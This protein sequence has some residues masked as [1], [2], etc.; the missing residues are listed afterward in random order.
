[1]RPRWTPCQ[2]KG[3]TSSSLPGKTGQV[4]VSHHGHIV[5]PR[6]CDN[7]GVNQARDG[8][9][10]FHYYLLS[11]GCAVSTW[12]GSVRLLPLQLGTTLRWESSRESSLCK[13]VG[14]HALCGAESDYLSLVSSDLLHRV[15]VFPPQLC[16]IPCFKHNCCCKRIGVLRSLPTT[17][18]QS[19]MHWTLRS[20]FH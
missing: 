4:L 3:L 16:N 5:L 1:M 2:Y 7:I 9:A 6:H 14:F 20:R 18:T 8:Q 13:G 11:L 17:V 15:R 10:L 12:L 19:T